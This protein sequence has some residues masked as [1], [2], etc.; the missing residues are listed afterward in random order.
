M[1]YRKWT[2]EEDLALV[3]AKSEDELSSLFPGVK[4][5]T[6]KRRRRLIKAQP[7]VSEGTA[8]G[9]S[10]LERVHFDTRN[11]KGIVIG[12]FQSPH[13]NRE[14]LAA[15]NYLLAD[16]KDDLDVIIDDG[17]HYDN[18]AVSRY[19]KDARRA[20]LESFKEARDIGNDIFKSWRDVGFG[21]DILLLKGNHEQ[22]WDNYILNEA[23]DKIL[24]F[25]GDSL[26]FERVFETGK[27]GVISFP[28]M[29]PVLFG[30]TVITHG[31]RSSTTTPGSVALK[32]IRQRFGTSVIV[33]HCHSGALVTQRYTHGTAIG[34]E[35]YTMANLD[36]L[37]YAMFPNWMNGFTYLH[38]VE[39]VGHM[40]TVPMINNTFVFNGKLYT[41]KGAR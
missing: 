21:G 4:V 37:G 23:S 31:T 5:S 12:D 3:R 39:G 26:S 8:L 11:F 29:Q 41:P 15:F 10:G 16:I 18:D 6:L 34:I 35:N 27:Y 36:E 7:S 25:A 2:R 17:D 33:G 9:L 19:K 38:M 13:H 20:T 14:A 40:Q 24:E 28:Y 1:S 32:E 30:N 22:R